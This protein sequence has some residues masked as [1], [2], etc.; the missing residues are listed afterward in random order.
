M[1][2]ISS[3]ADVSNRIVWT[4]QWGEL[5]ATTEAAAD[6]DNTEKKS[7]IGKAVSLCVSK[8]GDLPALI[9]LH[10]FG[11]QGSGGKLRYRF[12]RKFQD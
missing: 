4:L 12:K 2:E 7:E 5:V 10:Y 1:S 6:A 11:K 8:W 3:F 9:S